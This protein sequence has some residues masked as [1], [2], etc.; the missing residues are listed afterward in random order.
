MNKFSNVLAVVGVVIILLGLVVNYSWAEQTN[1][2][3][4][5]GSLTIIQSENPPS[6][7]YKVNPDTNHN[8]LMVK[9]D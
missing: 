4:D 3:G 8:E 1:V 6:V 5:D 2:W 7:T 9:I